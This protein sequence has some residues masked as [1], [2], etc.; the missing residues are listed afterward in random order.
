MRNIFVLIVVLLLLWSS[1]VEAKPRTFK[2]APFNCRVVSSNNG[3]IACYYSGNVY[4]VYYGSRTKAR[5][6]PRAGRLITLYF[7]V[8]EEGPHIPE[9]YDW[10]RAGYYPYGKF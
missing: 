4:S 1:A 5:T 6:Y 8:E 7:I 2:V 9:L 10:F 3:A